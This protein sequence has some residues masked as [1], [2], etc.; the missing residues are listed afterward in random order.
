MARQTTK[1]TE[2][3]LIRRHRMQTLCHWNRRFMDMQECR[4]GD[5]V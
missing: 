1:G 2:S 5:D 4:Q 3:L